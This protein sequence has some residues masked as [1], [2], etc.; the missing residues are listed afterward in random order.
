VFLCPFSLFVSPEKKSKGYTF[1]VLGSEI[2]TVPPY[3]RLLGLCTRGT[4]GIISLHLMAYKSTGSRHKM[5][6]PEKTAWESRMERF[7]GKRKTKVKKGSI[8]Y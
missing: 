1:T 6:A 5:L 3:Y 2:S 4:F 7:K 8:F